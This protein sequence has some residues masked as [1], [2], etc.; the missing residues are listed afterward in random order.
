MKFAMPKPLLSRKHLI[1]TLTKT[2][3]KK[4]NKVIFN[5]YRV[6]EDEAPIMQQLLWKDE[7]EL[8][9]FLDL[10]DDKKLRLVSSSFSKDVTV[11]A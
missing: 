3:E 10:R 9:M 6:F 2:K 1:R 4:L 5:I 11:F 8:N 7:D